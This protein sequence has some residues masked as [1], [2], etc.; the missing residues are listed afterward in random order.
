M[1]KMV[2][3]KKQQTND[4]DTKPQNVFYYLKILSQEA[5]DLMDEIKDVNDDINIHMLV[6]IGSNKEKCNFSTFRMPLNFLSAIYNGEI[7]LKG[8]KTFQRKIEKK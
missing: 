6:F 5:K 8:A 2:K 1:I 4:I 3:I 7:S